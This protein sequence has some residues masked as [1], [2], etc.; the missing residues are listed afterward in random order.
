LATVKSRAKDTGMV[1]LT[2]G[3][4]KGG[5][6]HMLPIA[7]HYMTRVAGLGSDISLHLPQVLDSLCRPGLGI[8]HAGQQSKSDV[9]LLLKIL[10]SDFLHYCFGLWIELLLVFQE[11]FL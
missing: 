9:L 1:W 11:I 3:G 4:G 7:L 10:S 5:V 8:L 6:G 2:V